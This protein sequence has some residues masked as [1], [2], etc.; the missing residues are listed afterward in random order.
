MALGG[1]P[2]P[3]SADLTVSVT[4]MTSANVLPG[5]PET[6]F[7]LPV[8]YVQGVYT[9]AVFGTVTT[10]KCG[11]FRGAAASFI[12]SPG[13]DKD[14]NAIILQTGSVRHFMWSS[15]MTTDVY[16]ASAVTD[17]E[18][19]AITHKG[20][21]YCGTC[22]EDWSHIYDIPKVQS[23]NSTPMFLAGPRSALLIMPAL[24][25]NNI[26]IVTREKAVQCFHCT[27]IS[28]AGRC[29]KNESWNLVC[30][31]KFI[32]S[33]TDTGAVSWSLAPASDCIVRHDG[34]IE[35]HIGVFSV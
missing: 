34:A 24:V 5:T 23:T 11:C 30:N 18:C 17:S 25:G 35:T 31:D 13:S 7:G 20:K 1:A 12:F 8:S 21:V 28:S 10:T 16:I 19:Y 22:R 27:D 2:E 33:V 4:T 14:R 6:F 15:L 32:I 26:Y 3:A 29:D 9:N